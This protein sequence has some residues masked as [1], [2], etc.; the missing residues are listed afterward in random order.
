MVGMGHLLSF[1]CLCHLLPVLPERFAA[2]PQAVC[3]KLHDDLIFAVP[4]K[5][6]VRVAACCVPEE[7]MHGVAA[8]VLKALKAVENW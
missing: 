4:L 6:G 1:A 3:N 2:D 7:K 8:K 5:M